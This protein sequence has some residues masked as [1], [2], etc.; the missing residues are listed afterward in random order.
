MIMPC[1]L[2]PEANEELEADDT[3]V[4]YIGKPP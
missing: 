3:F 2:F 1:D 4:K